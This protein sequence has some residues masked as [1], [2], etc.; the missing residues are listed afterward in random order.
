MRNFKQVYTIYIG[1]Y[2][3]IR[4]L[5][6]ELY[7]EVIVS[8]GSAS[9]KSCTAAMAVNSGHLWQSTGMSSFDTRTQRDGCL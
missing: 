2:R 8:K 7:Y 3:E 5:R 9:H 4:M 6:P 1:E